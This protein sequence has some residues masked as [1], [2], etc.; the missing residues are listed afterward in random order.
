MKNVRNDNQGIL[1]MRTNKTL[2]GDELQ[3]VNWSYSG[4]LP[5]IVYAV[6]RYMKKETGLTP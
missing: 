6:Y 5:Q 3:T 4:H 1:N 2:D